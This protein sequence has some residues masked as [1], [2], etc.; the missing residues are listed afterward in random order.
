MEFF[1]D[2]DLVIFDAQY[3][4]A[5][6]ISVK[7]DWGHSS[8]VVGVEMCQLARRPAPLP[9]PSRADLRRR[10]HRRAPGRDAPPRGDHPRRTTASRSTPPTTGWRSR[11]EGREPDRHP[12]GP[13]LPPAGEAHW[14]ERRW[15]RALLG[16]R[17]RPLGALLLLLL[18]LAL[19]VPELPGL[20][21]VR[22]AAFDAY[23]S[24]APRVP[25]SAP[26]VIVA[27][28]EESLRRYG[29]WPWPRTLAGPP[30]RACRAR[31]G[32]PS[33]GSTS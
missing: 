11:C 20:G 15:A 27:I 25:R 23:Q 17:G 14:A 30:R 18:V 1:R 5:D 2:A 26:V 4:L 28:D 22:L 29:Q 13:A 16:G 32:R 33:S 31:R 7:E 10:A 3:S 12:E 24:L 6:A 9:L 8:N 19:L 21:R